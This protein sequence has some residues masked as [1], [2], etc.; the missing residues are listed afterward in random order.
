MLLSFNS[1]ILIFDDTLRNQLKEKTIR[2]SLNK[3][4]WKKKK[5]QSL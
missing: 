4:S 2:N 5:D 1:L 3:I